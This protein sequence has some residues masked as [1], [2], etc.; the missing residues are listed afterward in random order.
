[1][2]KKTEINSVATFAPDMSKPSETSCAAPA[3][4]IAD[5]PILCPTDNPDWIAIEPAKIPQGTTDKQS[6]SISTTP[7]IKCFHGL[8][9]SFDSDDERATVFFI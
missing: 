7:V 6:G 4:I 8:T 2:I 1:M 5:I 9:V 3:K